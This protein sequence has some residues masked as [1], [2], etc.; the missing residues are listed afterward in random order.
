MHSTFKVKNNNSA[1]LNV[2][3]KG[4]DIQKHFLLNI[5]MNF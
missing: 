4:A 2:H 5:D 3:K 1:V